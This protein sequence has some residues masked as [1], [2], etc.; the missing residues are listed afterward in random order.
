MFDQLAAPVL[1][2]PASRPGNTPQREGEAMT[3]AAT[4]LG[5]GLALTVDQVTK[6][7]AFELVASHGAIPVLPFLTITSSMNAGVAFGIGT[8]VHPILLIGVAAT[9][10]ALLL[11]M[12]LRSASPLYRAV[13]G[14]I[15]GGGIG[16]IA[17]RLRFGAVRDFI[18]LHWGGS[19]W[20]TFNMADA[21]ITV[22]F[23]IMLIACDE[24]NGHLKPRSTRC[25]KN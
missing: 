23:V 17:D 25:W 12:I 22:G 20:P 7:A 6:P 13:L 11:A 8:R 14:M 9:V 2:S 15:L 4:W 16:N 10:T 24:S 21:F 1:D 19:H 5:A 18:D 3:R